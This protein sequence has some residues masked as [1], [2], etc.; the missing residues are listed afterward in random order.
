[1]LPIHWGTFNLALHPWD[2]PGE[3]TLAAAEGAGAAVALPI[4]GQPF[5]PGTAGAPSMPWWRPFVA[6]ERTGGPVDGPSAVP[7]L[8][9]GSVAGTAARVGSAG[10]GG[11]EK[12]ESVGS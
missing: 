4:P 1:M 8:G 9:A 11:Q 2:E 7:P 3:G 6:G 5:E 10:T 12:P